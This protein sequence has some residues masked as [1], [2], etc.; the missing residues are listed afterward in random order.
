MTGKIL[1]TLGIMAAAVC[2]CAERAKPPRPRMTPPPATDP[3]SYAHAVIAWAEAEPESGPAPLTVHFSVDDPFNSIQDPEYL[4][5]FGDGSATS[6][7]G[8]PVHVYKRPGRYTARLRV[9][10]NVG[11]VDEDTVEIEVT[12]PP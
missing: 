9:T 11:S 4:W 5:D 7:K 1:L 10:D 8:K 3:A 6:D 12:S 2:G